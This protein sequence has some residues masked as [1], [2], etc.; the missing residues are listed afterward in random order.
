MFQELGW[1]LDNIQDA[2]IKK[3]IENEI[4]RALTDY[5][6]PSQFDGSGASGGGFMPE[7]DERE[8]DPDVL[9][10]SRADQFVEKVLA[11][12]DRDGDGM[13][14]I[15]DF[16]TNM[17]DVHGRGVI[18]DDEYYAVTELFSEILDK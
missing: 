9:F 16:W 8:Y 1:V 4:G 11:V 18:D 2:P 3:L 6:L 7:S 10:K 13:C 5:D 12:C 15:D 14:I 17:K